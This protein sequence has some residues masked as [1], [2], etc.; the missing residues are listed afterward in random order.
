MPRT[1]CRGQAFHARFKDVENAEDRH[2]TFSCSVQRRPECRGQAFH[3]LRREYRGQTFHAV[4]C[5]AQTIPAPNAEDR[6]FMPE[7]AEDNAEDRRSTCFV[8]NTEDRRSTCFVE[9]TEDR[10]FTLGSNDPGCERRGHAQVPEDARGHARVPEDRR[11]M[12]EE[13]RFTLGSNDPGPANLSFFPFARPP[14][15]ART[16]RTCPNA[17]DRRCMLGSN[18]PGPLI[19]LSRGRRWRVGHVCWVRRPTQDCTGIE[20][21]EASVTSV[22]A[23]ATE[24]NWHGAGLTEC[25]TRQLADSAED[26]HAQERPSERPLTRCDPANHDRPRGPRSRRGWPRVVC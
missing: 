3:V 26:V 4:S 18:D 5:L 17:E 21:Q 9:N 8:E 24:A 15:A 14:M 25:N 12:P 22:C 16:P 10:R 11:F 7:N 23:L 1:E 19:C 6:R 2:F 13:R 20:R